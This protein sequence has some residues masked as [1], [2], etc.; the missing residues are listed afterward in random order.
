VPQVNS[1][2]RSHRV[3]E[4]D[5]DSSQRSRRPRSIRMPRLQI[6]YLIISYMVTPSPLGQM[7]CLT[8]LTSLVVEG[9]MTRP[10]ASGSVAKKAPLQTNPSQTP[11][12]SLAKTK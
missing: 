2:G 1:W 9:T 3:T 5:A 6:N 10:H 8:G 7:P 4:G 11:A 12:P